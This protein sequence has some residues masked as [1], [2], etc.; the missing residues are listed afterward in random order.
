M[1][2]GSCRAAGSSTPI[3]TQ[4]SSGRRRWPKAPLMVRTKITYSQTRPR[5]TSPFPDSTAAKQAS[6]LRPC[7]HRPPTMKHFLRK[8]PTTTEGCPNATAQTLSRPHHPHSVRP[9][10]HPQ[11]VL[12]SLRNYHA[13]SKTQVARSTGRRLVHQDSGV[14]LLMAVWSGREIISHS[15]SPIAVVTLNASPSITTDRRFNNNL[16]L[17]HARATTANALLS[18]ILHMRLEGM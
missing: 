16:D 6:G 13:I 3:P 10:H 18:A 12:L 11:R 15:A 14:A 5:P 7:M 4:E 8:T 1:T 9:H 17:R 2:A